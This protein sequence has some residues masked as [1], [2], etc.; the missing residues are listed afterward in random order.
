LVTS[1]IVATTEQNTYRVATKAGII[2]GRLLT[3]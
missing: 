3:P 1:A 2:E